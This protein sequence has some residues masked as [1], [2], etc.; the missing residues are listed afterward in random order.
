MTSATIRALRTAAVGVL[1]VSASGC[2]APGSANGYV[3]V[4]GALQSAS[5]APLADRE[6]Q[7]IL[8]REYGLGGLDLVLGDAEDFGHEDRKFTV[9][10]DANGEFAYDLGRHIYHITFWLLPPL[11]GFPRHPP[12]PALFVR[13]PSFP[14]EYY[15]VH[16][17]DGRFQVRGTGGAELPAPEA[18][19]AEL[20][21]TSQSGVTGDARWTIGI[22]RLRFR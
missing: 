13:V 10:T 3:S 2:I 14:G 1:V 7:L 8:P 11:G 20:V 6:V 17:G 18:K 5:G 21:A 22:V 12:P 9:V 15:A 19:L 16:T 4:R